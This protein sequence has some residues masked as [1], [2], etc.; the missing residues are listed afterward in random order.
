MR[1]KGVE[2]RGKWSNVLIMKYS[3]VILA[4]IFFQVKSFAVINGTAVSVELVKVGN[5]N[6]T[7]NLTNGYGSVSYEYF[8]S[9]YE[10]T[11]GEWCAFL[12]SVAK[13]SSAPFYSELYN[14]SMSSDYNSAGILRIGESGQFQYAVIGSPRR[15]ITYVTWISAAMFCNWL[16]NGQGTNSYLYGSYEQLS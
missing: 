3:L 16:Q 9:K 2:K 10:V 15:P 4:A 14:T 1:I 13:T 6:N 7:P 11:I 8:I 5:P 12:N